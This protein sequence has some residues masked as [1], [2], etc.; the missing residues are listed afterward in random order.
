MAERSGPEGWGG[1]S[2]GGQV[3]Q[4]RPYHAGGDAAGASADHHVGDLVAP[5]PL[6]FGIGQEGQGCLLKLFRGLV[7]CRERGW[8]QGSSPTSLPG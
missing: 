1:V 7:G 3:A 5:E 8:G 2:E 6:A 4:G